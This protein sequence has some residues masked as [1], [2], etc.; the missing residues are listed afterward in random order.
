VWVIPV[1]N[2]LPSNVVEHAAVV[3][4]R[5]TEPDRERVG[6]VGIARPNVEHVAR[7][8]R[9][10]PTTEG[11]L[12]MRAEEALGLTVERCMQV[13]AFQLEPRT[14]EGISHAR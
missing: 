12:V 6:R 11:G 13:C 10:E 3:V 9:F 14:C 7:E 4:D 1:E 2:K 8:I 5:V